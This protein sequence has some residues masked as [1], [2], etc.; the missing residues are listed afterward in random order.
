MV[1]SILSHISGTRQSMGFVQEYSID[2]IQKKLMTQ[3]FNKFK[4]LCFWSAF[5]SFFQFLGQKKKKCPGKSSSITHK[6]I[7]VSSTCQNLE[8]VNNAIQRKCPDRRTEGQV[9]GW[10]DHI[11]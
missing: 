10:I 6:F 5:G 9:K 3:F 4:K 7:W 2:Q 1:E 8:K 11:L